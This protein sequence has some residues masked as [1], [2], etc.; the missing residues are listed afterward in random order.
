MKNLIALFVIFAVSVAVFG[1]TKDV[2]TIKIYLSDGN[3]NPNFENCGKV[4]HVMRTI[5][6]TKAVAKAALDELVKGATEA[7]KAQ[8]LSSIFSVETKSIIKNVNIKKDAAYVNLD[9]WVI[10]N[11]GT[12]TTSCGAFTFITPIEKTLMQFSTVKRVFFAIEG[13]PKDF[14][15]WMQVG[16][17]P[18]ELKNCDGRNF[19]K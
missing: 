15:E 19:K 3:D 10:E 4:R 1:Q 13:K 2:M 18:K 7:E 11:L 9:D 14:Y 6:K 8:N 16:E 17:C 5:P 12:A